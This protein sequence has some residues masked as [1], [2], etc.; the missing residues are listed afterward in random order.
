[1]FT[2]FKKKTKKK[3]ICLEVLGSLVIDRKAKYWDGM[4]TMKAMLCFYLLQ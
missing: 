3:E 4:N 1:M 2:G